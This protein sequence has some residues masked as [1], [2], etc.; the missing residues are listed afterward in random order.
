MSLNKIDEILEQ[1][2][3]IEQ[4]TT[5]AV[6]QKRQE[7]KFYSILLG[8]GMEEKF[9]ELQFRDG[10]RLCLNYNDLLWFH[11]IPDEHC[12]DMEF[13]GFLI[14]IKGRGMVPHLFNGLKQKKVSWI[15]EAD[16]EMQDHLANTTYIET[17]TVIPPKGF[18]AEEE[19]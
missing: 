11:H 6:Q 16:V 13:A 14:S 18:S 12:I 1:R 10:L 9:L 7:D 19:N 5:P 15:K 4:P 3:R 17:I 2:K 8:D